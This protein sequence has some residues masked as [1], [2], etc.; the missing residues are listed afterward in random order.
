[1]IRWAA[2]AANQAVVD[3]KHLAR[4]PWFIQPV[5][6]V[7]GCCATADYPAITANPKRER[8]VGIDDY[9]CSVLRD[10]I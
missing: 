8:T 10:T 7:A 3:A 2:A 5:G 1:V 9:S 4:G 6:G